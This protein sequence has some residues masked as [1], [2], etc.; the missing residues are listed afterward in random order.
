M[1]LPKKASGRRVFGYKRR[2]ICCCLLG[3]L[4]ISSKEALK[5]L[6]KHFSGIGRG[7]GGHAWFVPTSLSMFRVLIWE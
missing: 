1:M 3:R 4:K 5:N 7:P 6:G 2:L